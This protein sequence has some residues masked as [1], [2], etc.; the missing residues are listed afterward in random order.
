MKAVSQEITG[1]GQQWDLSN[2]RYS[3]FDKTELK[4]QVN[5]KDGQSFS[6]GDA[7]GTT[8]PPRTWSRPGERAQMCKRDSGIEFSGAN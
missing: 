7:P 5:F 1:P 3:L 8:G 2:W 6:V 4:T